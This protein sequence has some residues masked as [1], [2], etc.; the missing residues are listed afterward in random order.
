[1]DKEAAPNLILFTNS[2]PSGTSESFLE[3]EVIFLSQRFSKVYIFPL[4]DDHVKRPLP[5][6]V[7]SHKALLNRSIIKRIY[8][9]IL[10]T[11]P[12]WD[13]L[14]NLEYRKALKNLKKT[15]L[16]CI[17]TRSFL[18]NS[19]L[20]TLLQSN[21]S[22]P[23]Y[24]YWGVGAANIVPYLPGQ[25]N[26]F[27]RF[28]GYDLYEER[29]RG[30]IPFR[31][32]LLEK[33]TQGFTISEHG[34][35]YLT[36]KYPDCKNRIQISRIG[37]RKGL[38]LKKANSSEFK[39]V[40]CSNMIPLKRIHLIIEALSLIDFQVHWTHIGDG[41]LYSSLTSQAKSLPSHICYQF[42]GQIDNKQ[43]R[44]YYEK[45]DVNLF[46]NVSSTE[47]VPVSIMEALSFGIPV[48][49]TDVGGTSELVTDR[50]FL[51]KPHISPRQ[52]ASKI[53]MMRGNLELCDPNQF[54][55]MW[56]RKADA[57]KVYPDFITRMMGACK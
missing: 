19:E 56:Q 14:K 54:Q 34:L 25:R 51:L 22:T 16:T 45:H 21:L 10:N 46:I 18:A 43:V 17:E 37:V 9:G 13:I 55:D 53:A 11:S 4:F 36:Q 24:F 8:R 27:V 26:I 3:N 38:S 1:M 20:N 35:K 39:I 40:T 32:K 47:G 6:N 33:I 42:L 2:F 52:L 48:L 44:R 7:F 49:A 12:I 30:Y 57:D 29:N 50:R 15:V 28:H 41:P 31:A 5:P 23:L